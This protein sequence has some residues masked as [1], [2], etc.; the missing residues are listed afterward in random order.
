MNLE[1]AAFIVGVSR[2]TL[3]DYFLQLKNARKFNFDF[4]KHRNSKMGV[5]RNFVK[6]NLKLAESKGKLEFDD[7]E[8]R[9]L[10]NQI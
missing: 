5:L 6:Q 1:E 10:F 8:E 3:E 4:A 7:E 9:Q 2:K